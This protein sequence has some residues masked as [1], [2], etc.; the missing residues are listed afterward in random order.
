MLGSLAGGSEPS[1]ET[2]LL[3]TDADIWPLRNYIVFGWEVPGD[4]IYP[5]STST[6]LYNIPPASA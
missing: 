4:Q 6:Y 2:N 1:S 5:L 3:S